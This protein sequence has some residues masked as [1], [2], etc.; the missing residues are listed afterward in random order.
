[1]T[2]VSRQVVCWLGDSL[3]ASF[4][5]AKVMIRHGVSMM[6][7]GASHA[8][9]LMRAHEC[10]AVKQQCRVSCLTCHVDTTI[11]AVQSSWC[12]IQG[13]FSLL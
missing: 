11:T 7:L 10:H 5:L 13:L 2:M 6:T 8:A 9:H 4:P 3:D 12:S 1:M